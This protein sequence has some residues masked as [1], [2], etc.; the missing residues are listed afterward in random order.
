MAFRPTPPAF[1]AM[2]FVPGANK[3]AI[4]KAP[5]LGADA[6]I[7]DLEDSLDP[8]TRSHAR[9]DVR[10]AVPHGDTYAMVR[11]NGVGTLD[12]GADIEI[13]QHADAVVLPKVE[14]PSEIDQVA[15]TLAITG[16][17]A[18]IWVMIESPMGVLNVA[19]IANHPSVR[20]IIVGPNDLNRTIGVETTGDRA[21]ALPIFSNIIV[22]AKA[23][24]IPVIDGVFNRFKD[25]TGFI[26]ETTQGR[27]L[28]F[29]GKSLIH[30]AQVKLCKNVY[31]PSEKDIERA[32]QLINAYE[33]AGGGVT[34][35]DGQMIEALHVEMAK[36][37]L[38]RTGTP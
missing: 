31:A 19:Q 30:P 2:L 27:A 11:V 26:T 6:I 17:Q 3:R 29:D 36:K 18:A 35:L 1:H 5:T 21:G 25:E 24:G 37:L 15:Q 38:Q 16:S 10:A 8:T 20:G 14:N 12:H 23:F 22:A 34:S 9:Q 33:S 4:Q 13:A 28:G 7:Y 32:K